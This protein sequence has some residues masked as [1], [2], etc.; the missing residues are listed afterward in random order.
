MDPY[1]QH[2]WTGCDQGELRFQ[3]CADCAT[4]Q[5]F[6]RNHCLHCDSDRVAWQV[7]KGIGTIYSVTRVERAPTEEFRALVPY[8]IVLVD[9]DEG[10]RVMA[11]ANLTLK[12]GDKA[13]V[14]FFP[15]DNRSLPRFEPL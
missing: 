13:R 3:R 14:T 2:F 8:A 9:L 15:H 5:F 1:A 6:P 12:I 10:V 4:A 7:S 11:H